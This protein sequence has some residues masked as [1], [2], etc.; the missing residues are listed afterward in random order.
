[1]KILIVGGGVAGPALA[2]FLKKNADIT[3]IDKAPKWGDVGFAVAIWGNGQHML[4]KM[5]IYKEVY[6]QAYAMP[7]CAYQDSGGR[8]LERFLF[9]VFRKY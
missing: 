3:L 4:K 5:G 9:S 1:M 2:V 8:V 6:K 7:W